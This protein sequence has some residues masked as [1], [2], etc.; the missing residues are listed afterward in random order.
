MMLKEIYKLKKEHS[1]EGLA[2]KGQLPFRI[3]GV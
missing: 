2:D 1:D 3:E